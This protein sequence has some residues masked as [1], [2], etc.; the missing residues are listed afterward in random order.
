MPNGITLQAWGLEEFRVPGAVKA[1]ACAEGQV[2]MATLQ[3]TTVLEEVVGA[4][5]EASPLGAAWTLTFVLRGEALH[6]Q[7]QGLIEPLFPGD[8][9]L[10]HRVLIIPHHAQVPP[11][12]V[13]EGLQR[14][15]GG[16]HA[17]LHHHAP[18]WEGGV[19]PCSPQ[20]ASG[21][22]TEVAASGQKVG[23]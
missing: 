10:A 2:S 12:L 8:E 20:E 19:A 4:C 23:C 13:Q 16:V 5:G 11:D 7:W 14:H 1:S 6:G 15:A 18:A 17:V 9:G 21:S 3:H 22:G